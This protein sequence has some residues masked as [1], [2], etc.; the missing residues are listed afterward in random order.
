MLSVTG[1]EVRITRVAAWR[2][3]PFN[4]GMALQARPLLVFNGK[5]DEPLNDRS[6][7]NRVAVGTIRDGKVVLIGAFA[8]HNEGVTLREFAHDAIAIIGPSLVSL[9]NMDG[10]PSAFLTSPEVQLF[11][12]QGTVTTYIC[13]EAK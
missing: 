7:W 8:P 9:L 11:P 1:G 5:V 2:S 13:A 12:S 10:G 4:V 6:R 3:S